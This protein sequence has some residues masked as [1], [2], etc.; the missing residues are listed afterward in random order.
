MALRQQRVDVDARAF[1]RGFNTTLA[2]ME[3]RAEA[4][5]N[6]A[7]EILARGSQANVPIEMGDLKASL[8]TKTGR[9]RQTTSRKT[10][11]TRGN[12]YFFEVRYSDKAAWFQELGTKE[13][14]PQPFVRPARQAAARRLGRL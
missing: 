7:G 6:D 9:T 14:P 11:I 2:D 4:A 12:N 5:V 10:G 1:V 13:H 8:S 3:R